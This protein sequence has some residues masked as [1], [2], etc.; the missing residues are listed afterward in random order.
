MPA[1]AHPSV[2][3]R[4]RFRY[5]HRKQ[6]QKTRCRT[7]IFI[8][9]VQENEMTIDQAFNASVGYYDDWMKKALP[10]YDDLFG[11][12]RKLISFA[13]SRPIDVLDLGAGTGLFSKHVLEKYPQARFVLFDAADKM[14]EAARE[15]FHGCA[16]QFEYVVGDYRTLNVTREFDLVISSLSIHHLTDDEKRALFRSI[17][18]ILR[19]PG[20]FLNIDQIRGETDYLRDMYWN[21]WLGQVRR[22]E[23]S[24]QRIQESMQR[25][26]TYDRDA[27]LADQLQ[28]LREAGF[29]NVDCVYKHHF[30]GVFHAMKA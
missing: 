3:S 21:F 2:I 15:R 9:S 1:T 6:Q 29:V 17:H 13:P 25:R 28:W 7:A 30:V 8:L 5:P 14:L 12:A 10:N 26:V 27:S 18:G 23:S 22:L 11:T 24:E 19:T 16:R 4:N 20:L